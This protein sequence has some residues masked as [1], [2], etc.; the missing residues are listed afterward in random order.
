MEDSAS[1]YFL[2]LHVFFLHF[3]VL[4]Y[5]HV[6]VIKFVDRYE[7]EKMSGVLDK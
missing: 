4:E 5:L 7:S 3:I 1:H 2:H 6:F